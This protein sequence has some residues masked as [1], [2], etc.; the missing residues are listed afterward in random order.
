MQTSSCVTGS[1]T[2]HRYTFQVGD[3]I[4]KPLLAV[5]KI[6]ERKKAV[7][8]GPAPKFESYIIDD[9]EA[10]VVGNGMK[11]DIERINGTYHMRCFE[12]S[13]QNQHKCNRVFAGAED[14]QEAA[15]SP[16]Q[17]EA[18]ASPEDFAE[19]AVVRVKPNPLNP[20]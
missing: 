1:G 18:L 8:F 19:D 17:D 2:K 20:T 3:K 13:K 16:A 7:F 12:V 4:T 10:F 14:A 6:C 9:P 5:S 11:T 15:E